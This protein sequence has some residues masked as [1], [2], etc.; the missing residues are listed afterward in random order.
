MKNSQGIAIIY[1]LLFGAAFLL[2][3]GGLL[4]FI[5]FQ[6]QLAQR[7]IAWENSLQIAE[8]GINYYWYI[9]NHTPSGQNPDIQDGKSWCCKFEGIEYPWDSPQCQE[10]D[11]V[12]CGNCDGEPCYEHEFFPLGQITSTGKFFLRIKGKK[13]CDQILGVYVESIGSTKKYPNIKRKVIAKFAATSIGEFA[14]VLNSNSWVGSDREIFGKFHTNAGIRFD[15]KNN[16]LVTSAQ[17]S[18]LC[19]SAFDCESSNCPQGCTPQG[20]NCLCNGVAGNGGPKDY[21]KFPVPPFDFGAIT[22]D[23]AKMKNLAQQKGKYY[24]PSTNLNPN[25]KGYHLIFNPD[26]TYQIRIVTQIQNVYA[27]DKNGDGVCSG[28]SDWYWSPEKILSEIPLETTTTPQ[29]CGLIF[30]EDNLW[31]EGIVQGKKTVAAADLIHPNVDPTI[32]LNS[33]LDYTNLDG[34]DSL[35]VLAEKDVLIPCDSPDDM[36][37]RGVFL[38]QLGNFGRRFYMDPEVYPLS[39]YLNPS[40]C[41][42]GGLRNHLLIHGSII[43]NK[44]EGTKWEEISGYQKREVYFDKSIARDPPPLLPYVSPS[45]EIISWEESY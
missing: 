2:M 3:L 13:I 40:K 11:F 39:C 19:T 30:V 41:C 5:L 33:N 21:W 45:L 43:S 1:V 31:V 37:A 16:S 24:P 34:S 17:T 9:L 6:L 44:R 27:C 29:N 38:A 18:W 12:I 28:S 10:G 35:A 22:S 23:F 42:S 15:G 14:Y 8:A 25:G 26:G 7:K 36:I 20:S 4:G 32:F